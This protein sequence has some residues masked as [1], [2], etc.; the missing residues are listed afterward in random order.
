LS[1]KMEKVHQHFNAYFLSNRLLIQFVVSEFLAVYSQVHQLKQ[2]SHL[3]S[4]SPGLFDELLPQIAHSIATLQGTPCESSRPWGCEWRTGGLT[5]LKKYCEQLSIN[6]F[7]Q[8]KIHFQMNKNVFRVWISCLHCFEMIKGL[9][10]APSPFTS[11][12]RP[13]IAAPLHHALASMSTSL[14][15]V[16]KLLLKALREFVD[17]EMIVLFLHKH[18]EELCAIY[19]PHA[20]ADFTSSNKINIKRTSESLIHSL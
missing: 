6:T 2:K 15:S 8:N 14:N 19:G 1:V 20:M 10:P 5:K 11:T 16:S 18:K 12:V 9:Q 3:L 7:H 4:A 17:D 13:M